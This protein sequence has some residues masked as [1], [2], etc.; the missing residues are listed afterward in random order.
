MLT[1]NMIWIPGGEFQMGSSNFYPEEQP[2]NKTTVNG[3]WIDKTPVTKTEFARFVEAT[4]YKSVAERALDPEEYSSIDLEN[5]EPGSFVFKPT[6]GP[7]NL[8]NPGYWWEFVR[9]A[10]WRAPLGKPEALA[11]DH[12]VVQVA[13]EDVTAL[14]LIHI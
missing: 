8:N 2:T 7:V 3:F 9:G 6:K 1:E 5:L 12:P 13:F 4:D 10:N 11:S 14:S